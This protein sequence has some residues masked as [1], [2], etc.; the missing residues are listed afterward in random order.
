MDATMV[1]FLDLIVKEVMNTTNGLLVIWFD[2]I[3]RL[4]VGSN[5]KEENF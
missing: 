2:L 4:Q 3:S 5:K 1:N